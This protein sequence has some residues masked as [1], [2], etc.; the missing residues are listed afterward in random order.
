MRRSYIVILS[1]IL[2]FLGNINVYGKEEEDID[3]QISA[4]IE[5]G[6]YAKASNVLFKHATK[7][8][9]EGHTEDALTYQLKNVNLVDTY[10]EK[11]FEQGYTLEDYF[12]NWL[13]VMSWEMS[14]KQ[15]DDAIRTYL[16]LEDALRTCWP[17]QLPFYMDTVDNA[18]C[19]TEDTSLQDSIKC[20]QR[21]MNVIKTLPTTEENVRRYVSFSKTFY[22]DCQRKSFDNKIFKEDKFCDIE[23]WFTANA[24]YITSLDTA[25]YKNYIVDYIQ[26]YAD[27]LYL[28]AG[29]YAAQ[30]NDYVK[31]ISFYNHEIKLL[32]KWTKLEPK[33]NQKIA[34]CYAKIAQDYFSLG[35]NIKSKEYCDLAFNSLFDHSDDYEYCDILNALALG[36]FNIHELETAAM[37]KLK[38]IET[39]KKLGGNVTLTDISM[40]MM[41]KKNSPKEVLS[42]QNLIDANTITV[43]SNKFHYYME[44]ENAYCALYNE[45]AA[46]KDSII[47]YLKLAEEELIKHESF[48]R[49][50]RQYSISWGNLYNAY[51]KYYSVLGEKI[52]SY[53]YSL[54]ALD[55]LDS[56]KY[57]NYYSVALKATLLRDSVGINKYLPLYYYGLEK[58]TC[59]MIPVLGSVESDTYLIYGNSELYNIPG[60]TIYNPD[61]PIIR[62][63]GYNALL[64][65]KGIVLR[66]NSFLNSKSIDKLWKDQIDHLNC[67]RDSIYLMNDSPERAIAIK[68]YEIKE[69]EI[70]RHTIDKDLVIHWEDVQAK[71]KSEEACVEFTRFRK[72]VYSWDEDEPTWHYAAY[73]LTPNANAPIFVDLFDEKDI[74]TAYEVQPKFLEEDYSNIYYEMLWGRLQTFIENKS[75]VYFSPDGILR[76]MNIEMLSDNTNMTALER[77]NLKRVSSTRT[78]IS[79]GETK[80]KSL[81]I[82]GFGGIDSETNV[83]IID[84]MNTRGNWAFLK[85]TMEEIN[86]IKETSYPCMVFCGKEATEKVFKEQCSRGFNILHIASHGYYVPPIERNNI[87]YYSKSEYTLHIQDELF[88]SGIIL[89]GGQRAW[90]ESYFAPNQDDG[91]LTSYEIS[92]LD[93]SN[94]DMVILSACESGLG[95]NLYDGIFGLQRA[96]KKAGVRTIM[97]SLW[98]IEDKATS[99]FMSKYYDLLSE[100]KN[101]YDSYL[102]TVRY[103]KELYPDPYYWA[104]FILL[105]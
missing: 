69:R 87:P 12:T 6:M 59:D 89:S 84:D 65:Q 30:T 71:L 11:V 66:N 56:D 28:Y 75:K 36:Y 46:Y 58:E 2:I 103:M 54:K 5:N 10:L 77:F 22:Y 82:L 39:Q 86:R 25:I 24:E 51:A 45:N 43:N 26:S 27:V 32:V 4:L 74:V 40:Y 83:K 72:N 85:G 53:N 67:R 20:L 98:K 16:E 37:L 48:L 3:I 70:A 9:D 96:F 81:N 15:Y 35:D 88:Y 47:H 63:I 57:Y 92:K 31:A 62:G 52:Q 41:Y 55:H 50:T 60:W 94:Y 76:L 64:L 100:G 90:H 34:A 29:T 93:L 21:A 78:L 1:L 8:N 95:D 68:Q 99:V 38:E 7:C 61:L 44:L 91:I 97:M 14:L 19:W 105:D 13:C 79:G 17:D 73:V 18:F 102:L 104:G 42:A 49:Q 23:N 101:Q 33:F 80:N